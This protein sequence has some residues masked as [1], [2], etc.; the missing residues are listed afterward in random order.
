MDTLTLSVFVASS[1]L[2]LLVGLLISGGESPLAVRLR[3]LGGTGESPPVGRHRAGK[4]TSP[5]MSAI[6]APL[7][8]E[9]EAEKGKLQVRL[10]HAGL[11]GRHA[12]T[13][14]AGIRVC[15][16]TI[17]LALGLMAAA[18]GV[19]EWTHSLIGASVFAIL[20][21]IAPS[22]WLDRRKAARQG[23]IRRALPDVMDMV[24]VCLDGGLSPVAALDKVAGEM[25]MA[26]P[27]IASELK[28]VIR[29]TELGQSTGEAL[30]QFAGRFDLEELRRLASMVVESDRFGTSVG[31]ILRVHAGDMRV[32]RHQ[33]AEEMARK[34]VVKLV[35]PTALCILPCIFV[36]VLVPSLVHIIRILDTIGSR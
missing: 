18:I 29:G 33:R 16:T 19:V 12:L 23:L 36:V 25:H 8:P 31:K 20:G 32:R 3:E 17:P 6:A 2:V 26:Y 28:L 14:F 5:W 10:I 30:Q 34:A 13:T 4:S 35:F 27:L 9:D 1:C 21:Y 7:V 22:F 24:V 11:Y 15:L